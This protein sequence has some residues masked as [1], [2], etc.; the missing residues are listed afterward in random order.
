[1]VFIFLF[2]LYFVKSEQYCEKFPIIYDYF[3]CE[4]Q[5][6]KR[7]DGGEHL[8]CPNLGT[9]GCAPFICEIQPENG[10][11]HAGFTHHQHD[12]STQKDIRYLDYWF[13]P[14]ESQVYIDWY[15]KF[16]SYDINGKGSNITVGSQ[17]FQNMYN[18]IGQ[19]TFISITL[20]VDQETSIGNLSLYINASLYITYN[21]D[22]LELYFL[23][24]V[25]INIFEIGLID[26]LQKISFFSAHTETPTLDQIEYFFSLGKNRSLDVEL[27]YDIPCYTTSGVSSG[28]MTATIILSIILGIIVLMELIRLIWLIYKFFVNSGKEPYQTLGSP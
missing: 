16:Y 24:S 6:T 15:T 4:F 28:Y 27:C 18:F 12:C 11:C 17:I 9:W 21:T 19:E 7:R 23:D 5:P 13:T 22:I 10:T 14:Q 26:N 25:A 3:N 1:M 20:E 8:V 2:L